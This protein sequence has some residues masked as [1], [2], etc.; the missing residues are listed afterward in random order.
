MGK[1]LRESC[2]YFPVFRLNQERYSASLRIQLEYGKIRTRKTPNRDNFHAVKPLGFFL[3]LNLPA[4]N[5][6]S[7]FHGNNFG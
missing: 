4:R 5:G 6:S 2:L 7:Y 1:A 3:K